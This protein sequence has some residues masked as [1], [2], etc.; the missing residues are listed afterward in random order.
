MSVRDARPDARGESGLDAP[1]VVAAIETTT[2]AL[3]A[4]RRPGATICPSEVA[5]ALAP[6]DWRPLMPRVREVAGVL[7]RAGR[8]AI[9]QRGVALD[10]DAEPRGAIRIARPVA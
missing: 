2:L 4:A 8:V 9:T 3:L 7:A 5:R 10:P 1:S 6:D